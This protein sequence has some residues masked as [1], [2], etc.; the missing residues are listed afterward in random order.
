MDN[1]SAGMPRSVS[2]F[3][4]NGRRDTKKQSCGP[5]RL[6]LAGDPDGALRAVIP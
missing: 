6:G 3:P 4:S 2:A 1:S 5:T